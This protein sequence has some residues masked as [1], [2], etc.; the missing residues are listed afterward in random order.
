MIPEFKAVKRAGYYSLRVIYPGSQLADGSQF[1]RL[2]MER[3]G[4]GAHGEDE[5]FGKALRAACVRA[6][7]NSPLNVVLAEIRRTYIE[8]YHGS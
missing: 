7:R 2:R 5:D 1:G 8:W 6:G 3:D 4:W